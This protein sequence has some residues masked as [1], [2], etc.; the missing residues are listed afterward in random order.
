[1][2]NRKSTRLKGY[3]YASEGGYFI[4]INAKQRN[5]DHFGKVVNGEMILNEAGLIVQNE[6]LKTQ[7]IR[8]QVILDEFVVMPDHFHAILF[9]RG[10]QMGECNSPVD[11]PKI[12][13]F[14]S[15]SQTLGAIIRGFKSACTKKFNEL[16]INMEW[17][18]N[19]HDRIIRNEQEYL[20]VQNYIKMNPKNFE[21][22]RNS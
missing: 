5:V 15:P 18:R 14:R 13:V 1:M 12:S 9:L 7:E 8:T 19:Y 3:D 22:N 6:W 4:T 10:I 11:E 20:N 17:Q 21:K 2:P 16:N